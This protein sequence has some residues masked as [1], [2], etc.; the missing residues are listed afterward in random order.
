MTSL[1]YQSVD[2]ELF[3]IIMPSKQYTGKHDQDIIRGE[4]VLPSHEKVLSYDN[5]ANV[6]TAD[7]VDPYVIYEVDMFST[8][9][10]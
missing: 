9:H 4:C 6:A 5:A 3:L 10:E 7:L 8:T 2:I 1:E